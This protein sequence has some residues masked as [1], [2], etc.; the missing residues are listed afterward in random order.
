MIEVEEA[1][2]LACFNVMAHNRDYH[3]RN[4][5]FL[6]NKATWVFAP[7]YDLTF[8]EGAAW[9]RNTM[10]MSEVRN[11]GVEH[12]KALWQGAT[13]RAT[14]GH[15]RYGAKAGGTRRLVACSKA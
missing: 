3:A 15:A 5:S 10:M 11:P 12:L 7:A 9:K 8:S 4:F 1:Y 14:L 6:L 13:R 2:A